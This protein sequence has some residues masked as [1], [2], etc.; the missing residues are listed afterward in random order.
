MSQGHTSPF[1]TPAHDHAPCLASLIERAE[2][3]FAAKDLRLTELRRQVLGEI[4]ASHRAIGA[5]EI[6]DRLARKGTRL[7]PI[8]VYRALDALQQAGVVHRLESRNA[9]FAC[10]SG[11]G[12]GSAQV[13]LSCRQ[14]GEIAEV[15]GEAVLAAIET[16]AAGVAF[17]AS[18]AIVEVSGLCGHCA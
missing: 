6:L 3:A 1:P 7:A 8:S 5:Y 17:R 11:H 10:H 14:C 2:A 13:V 4:A 18:G 9:Y 12:H 16:A 15:G